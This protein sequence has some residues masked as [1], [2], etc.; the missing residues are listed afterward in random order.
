MLA[1]LGIDDR[2]EA[3]YRLLL[4]RRDWGVAEYAEHL[5]MAQGEVREALDQLAELRLL[6]DGG[7]APGS[8]RAVSPKVGLGLLLQQQED[9]LLR[10]QLELAESQE[11]IL[12]LADEFADPLADEAVHGVEVLDGLDAIQLR[13]EEL[14]RGCSGECLSFMPGGAQSASSLE[15]SRPLDGAL[16][17]R[18]VEVL[19]LYQDSVRNDSATLRYAQWLTELGGGV[20]TAAVLPSRMVMFDRQT[21]LLPLDPDNSR[22]GAIQVSGPGLIAPLA[23]LFELV[24]ARAAPF[25]TARGREAGAGGPSEQEAALLGLL[26]Q[27]LTDDIAA[28]RL[29]LG[30]RTVRRMMSELMSRLEAR[31]RFEAGVRAARRNWVS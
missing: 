11:A 26:G 22:A 23:Q 9:A 3:V 13:L 18:G 16:L 25:G 29:G 21:A 1:A 2:T 7:Q 20:R 5:G 6:R 28:R 10:R 12:R 24:W 4:T 14:A 15:A 30:V 19:T 8:L 17:G 31:S 27:G